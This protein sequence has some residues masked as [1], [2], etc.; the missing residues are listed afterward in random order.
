M[1]NRPRAVATEWWVVIGVCGLGESRPYPSAFLQV[2]LVLTTN[3]AADDDQE[4]FST[5][6]TRYMGFSGQLDFL[7]AKVLQYGPGVKRMVQEAKE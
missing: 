3:D 7:L 5:E 4:H 6:D 1:G 2:S